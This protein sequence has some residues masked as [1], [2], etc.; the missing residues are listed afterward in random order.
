MYQLPNSAHL[1]GIDDLNANNN[2]IMTYLFLSF[3]VL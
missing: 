3:M 2:A 1:A